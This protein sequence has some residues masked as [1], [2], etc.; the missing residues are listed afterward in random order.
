MQNNYLEPRRNLIYKLEE[1]EMVLDDDKK[2]VNSCNK[3]I[4]EIMCEFYK[5]GQ[6]EL[7]RIDIVTTACNIASAARKTVDNTFK[8]WLIASS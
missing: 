8:I 2:I 1:Y 3:V 7:R 4:L 5:Q 6:E